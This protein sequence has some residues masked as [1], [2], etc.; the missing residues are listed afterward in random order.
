LSNLFLKLIEDL[1]NSL[2]FKK[3]PYINKLYDNVFDKLIL[4][5]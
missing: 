4:K 2:F 3:P 1:D 5:L